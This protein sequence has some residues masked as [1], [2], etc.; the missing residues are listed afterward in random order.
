[1]NYGDVIRQMSDEELARML[2]AVSIQ[3]DRD[4]VENL[5]RIGLRAELVEVPAMG[6]SY[7]LSAI[8]KTVDGEE[9]SPFE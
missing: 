9:A 2:Y 4:I 3:K 8:K 1:M 7:F 5:R 6:Y